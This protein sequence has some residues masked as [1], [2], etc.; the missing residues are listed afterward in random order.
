MK[1]KS[2]FSFTISK[3][4]REAFETCARGA[5]SGI[6]GCLEADARD[7]SSGPQLLIGAVCRAQAGRC[8]QQSFNDYGLG[9]GAYCGAS[10]H[11]RR[12]FLKWLRRGA[13][14]LRRR[15]TF[16]AHPISNHFP[17][18]AAVCTSKSRL[19]V[20]LLWCWTGKFGC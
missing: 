18:A 6:S 10:E 5:S 2:N 17:P 14:D 20:S 8:G 19:L 12:K 11:R 7:P 3:V 15:S 4:Y 16:F 13:F 1:Q 9:C